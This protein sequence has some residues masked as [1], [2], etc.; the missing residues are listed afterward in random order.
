MRE[1]KPSERKWII[2]SQ[3]WVGYK[4]QKWAV[5]SSK[6]EAD[7]RAANLNASP[8]GKWFHYFVEEKR[9]CAA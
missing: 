3:H 8:S 9:E 2:W 5:C 7:K 6:E 1:S 4:P